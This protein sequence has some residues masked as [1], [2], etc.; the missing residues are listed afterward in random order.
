MQNG[1]Y[2]VPRHPPETGVPPVTACLLSWKRPHHLPTIVAG[3]REC[4]FIDEIL[5]WNNN[6][7]LRLDIDDPI[8][9]VINS[10]GNAM[11]YGRYLCAAEA[12]NPI[13]YVQDDDAV[14]HGID[15]LYREFLA[16]P[17]RITHALL[18]SHFQLAS[19]QIYGSA[20]NALLGWGAFFQ[21]DWISVFSDLSASA[22]DDWLL[23]RE[24]D[25]VF[26]ILLNRQ[27]NPILGD[28]SLLHGHSEA[29]VA[30]WR[31]PAQRPLASLGIRLALTQLRMQN[32]PQAPPAWNV[33]ITCHNYGMFLPD[34]IESVLAN[35]ADYEIHLVDDASEDETVEVA[36]DYTSRYNHI[37][38][39][40]N[41]MQRG[42]AYSQN[43]GIKASASPYVVLLD[44]DDCIGPDY[45]YEAEQKLRAGADVVNPDA[46]LFGANYGRWIVPELTTLE[47]LL[48]RNPVHNCSAFRRDLW[49][50]V[51][52]IDEQMPR[53]MDHEFWIRV[54]GQNARIEA[55]H[56]DHFFYRRHERSLSQ[57]AA[58]RAWRKP[59]DWTSKALD[60]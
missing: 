45:L 9:R 20:Q 53:W 1:Q 8:T 30:L 10:E 48:K 25:K 14:N 16:D 50:R 17:S 59:V 28:V 46:I 33:V 38:Y 41:A 42:P 54:A 56:G 39:L 11:C 3:L 47:M 2:S 22:L 35:D 5:V 23:A 29:G 44:A 34:A 51:G 6:P 43:R 21:R 31:D 15:S 13:V 24:A 60:I 7:E 57:S 37:R 32:A 52:G 36:A 58:P 19:R 26:T 4:D 18:P 55:L 40:R 27:H 49:Q 12:K